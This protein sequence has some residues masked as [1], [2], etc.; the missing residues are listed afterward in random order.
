LPQDWRVRETPD[1]TIE[2]V[3]L[4]DAAAAVPFE[5]LLPQTLPEG[6]T[7]AAVELLELGDAVGVTAYFQAEDVAL[8]SG[9]IRVHLEQTEELPPT[10]APE[11]QTV[12]VRGVEG[13][14]TPEAARLEWIEG[15][16][17]VSIEAPGLE[18]TDLLALAS[19]VAPAPAT[20]GP[21][22]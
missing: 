20:P 11:Q 12:E 8:G 6:T 22:P 9:E 15:G 1:G 10:T 5:L 18:L 3:S 19:S 4:E 17:Y 16:V 7:L 21:T 2:R 14:Y 13:R